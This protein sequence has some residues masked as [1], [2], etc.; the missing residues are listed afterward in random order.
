MADTNSENNSNLAMFLIAIL[1]IIILGA[2]FFMY[3]NPGSQTQPPQNTSA[4][5]GNVNVNLNIPLPSDYNSTSPNTT[6]N[7]GY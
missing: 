3:F 6:N 4:P 7:S 2:I 1:V 5:S